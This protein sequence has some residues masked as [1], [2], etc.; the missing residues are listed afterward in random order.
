[1]KKIFLLLLTGLTLPLQAAEIRV[2]S[3][4]P[5]QAAIDNAA[6]GDTL[7]LG[8]GRFSG[9]FIIN[10]SLHIKG[11]YSDNRW[12]TIIDGQ[13]QH[14]TL[15]LT[16]PNVTIEGLK[17]VNWGDDLTAENAGIKLR[18]E[19]THGVI[20]NNYLEGPAGGIW[21]H[22]ASHSKV[23]NNRIIGD[24]SMRT[25]DRGNGIHLT[26]V[27]GVEVRGNEVSQTR[28]GLYIITSN[29][30]QLIDNYL[31]DLRFGVHYMYSYS[32]TVSG[33]LAENVRV[34]YALMQSKY[35][36]ILN[37]RSINTNDHGIL[38]NYINHSEIRGNYVDG[39]Q[40]RENAQATGAEAKALFVY[41]SYYN[42]LIDNYFANSQVGIHL[43]AAAQDNEISGNHFINNPVQVKYI[44]NRE[45]LWEGN[46]WSNYLGWDSNGDGIG[47]TTFE[48]NDGVDKLLWKYPEAKLLMDSPAVLTLRWVQRQFPVL[49]PKGV[50]DPRP[51]MRPQYDF[52]KFA[53]NPF[54]PQSTVLATGTDGESP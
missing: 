2:S 19:A 22:K 46:F 13:G 24:P 54:Q 50:K 6:P 10:K 41:N 12:A 37:N 11:D 26:M 9:N 1:M 18:P 42:K 44:T 14:E 33:N 20:K 49:K 43:T 3:D 38:L 17:I 16:A 15:R 36:K 40:Q 23:L 39:S 29:D 53:T 35:L 52:A 5:L 27:T 34:G 7:H 45:Q 51:L 48:P 31:H 8:A 28:D 32:N 30:N 25:S 21:L 47:D 4:M